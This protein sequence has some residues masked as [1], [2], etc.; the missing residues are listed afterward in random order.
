MASFGGR[1]CGALT[2]LAEL[3]SAL[4]ELGWRTAGGTGALGVAAGAHLPP[5][6]GDEVHSRGRLSEGESA[7]ELDLLHGD[8]RLLE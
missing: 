2:R 4:V 5:S 6:S 3:A 8:L 7:I 1:W